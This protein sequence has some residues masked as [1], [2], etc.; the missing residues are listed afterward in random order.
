MNDA[1]HTYC[2]VGTGKTYL[3]TLISQAL[4]YKHDYRP[5]VVVTASTGMAAA[6]VNGRWSFLADL[7][8]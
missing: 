4:L 5:A 8:Q 3:F 1:S 7:S 2:L 6:R